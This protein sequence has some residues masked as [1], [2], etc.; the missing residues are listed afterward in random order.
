MG[1]CRQTVLVIS[2]PSQDD[3]AV[4]VN[5]W[6]TA[7]IK[8]IPKYH[9]AQVVAAVDNDAGAAAANVA[10]RGRRKYFNSISSG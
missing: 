9:T 5:A 10:K 6:A 1:R 7:G 4:E 2:L 8:E 3:A